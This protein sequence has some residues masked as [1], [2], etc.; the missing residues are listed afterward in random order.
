MPDARGGIW[1]WEALCR[2]SRAWLL[3]I[4]VAANFLLPATHELWFS[5][6]TIGRLPQE[7]AMLREASLPGLDA[8]NLIIEAER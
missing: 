6:F 5:Q 1:Q 7:L 4:V 2:A 8:A 3:P